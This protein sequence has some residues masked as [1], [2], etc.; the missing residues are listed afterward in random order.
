MTQQYNQWPAGGFDGSA[1]G[2][3]GDAFGDLDSFQGDYKPEA[4]FPL[5]VDSLSPGDYD[6][7]V[8]SAELKKVEIVSVCELFLQVLGGRKVRWTWWLNKQS[9]VNQACADLVVLGFDANLWGTPQRP[10]S[11]E[12]PA[13]V[14]RLPG[15]KFRATKTQR[16]KLHQVTKQKTGEFWHNLVI[17][18]RI[19]GRPMPPLTP[20]IPATP[21]AVRPAVA[22][23]DDG[24][25]F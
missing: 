4:A 20:P 24:I 12:I 9:S 16:E 21:N 15:I 13:A 3:P 14:A 7:Q 2:G 18:C 1:P 6:F 22:P 5:D 19:D 8:L 17:N 10:L 25:P 11:K 23:I